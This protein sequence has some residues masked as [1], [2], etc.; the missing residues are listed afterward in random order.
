M[1]I[2]MHGSC[3]MCEAD[4][5]VCNTPPYTAEQAARAPGRTAEA[6]EAAG[7]LGRGAGRYLS[8]QV[9]AANMRAAARSMGVAAGQVLSRQARAT[10]RLR[11]RVQAVVPPPLVHEIQHRTPKAGDRYVIGASGFGE[12]QTPDEPNENERKV[13]QLLLGML[14]QATGVDL[15]APLPTVANRRRAIAL[16]F[17]VGVAFAVVGFVVVAGVLG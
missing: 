7:Q 11:E 2:G 9:A 16:G 5:C 10:R 4:P 6:L 1:A 8:A 3:T 12:W 17:A 13:D 14:S 15:D